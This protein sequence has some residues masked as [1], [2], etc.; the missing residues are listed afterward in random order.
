MSI[1]DLGMSLTVSHFVSLCIR[2]T[3]ETTDSNMAETRFKIQTIYID[4]AL[5]Y[6]LEFAWF[7]DSH[8]T[9]IARIAYLF[10]IRSNNISWN[11]YWSHVFN[12]LT[13][14][15]N[16]GFLADSSLEPFW[17]ERV[18]CGAFFLLLRALKCLLYIL[19]LIT[20]DMAKTPFFY[21]K[22]CCACATHFIRDHF[23]CTLFAH[24]NF[25]AIIT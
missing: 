1:C 7:L 12:M 22:L 19:Y 13:W 17:F 2:R 25:T 20:N 8:P 9:Q 11:Y 6:C 10:V 14:L 16:L 24:T 21:L 15:K 23:R 3:I 5:I 18:L 4:T